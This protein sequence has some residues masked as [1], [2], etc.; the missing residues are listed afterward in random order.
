MVNCVRTPLFSSFN[1]R[2]KKYTKKVRT[3]NLRSPTHCG[4]CFFF[5]NFILKTWKR[6]LN[7]FQNQHVYLKRKNG[8]NLF[9]FVVV[10]VVVV[11]DR[12]VWV[13]IRWMSDVNITIT[14]R[15][16]DPTRLSITKCPRSTSRNRNSS[17]G[18]P[19]R[20]S[21]EQNRDFLF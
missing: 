21:G 1:N 17:P 8:G 19:H 7:S 4:L 6:L 12:R 15:T 14:M 9:C 11:I 3:G 20:N 16:I 2:Q 18:C 5:K 13:A 10:V